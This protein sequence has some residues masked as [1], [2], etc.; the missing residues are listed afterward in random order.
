MKEPFR[1]ECIFMKIIDLNLE[2]AEQF[3]KPILLY[4]AGKYASIFLTY[5]QTRSVVEKIKVCVVSQVEENES[6]FRNLPVKCIDEIKNYEKYAVV[7]AVANKN[8]RAICQ[9]LEKRNLD[10]SYQITSG[11]ID[12]MA[13]KIADFFSSYSIQEKKVF[14]DCFEGL[15]YRCNC[16]YIAEELAKHD[17]KIVWNLSDKAVNDVPN[18]IKVVKRY[19]F[20]YFYEVYTAGIYITNNGVESRIYKRK[21]QKFICT[22]HGSGPFKKINIDLCKENENLKRYIREEYNNIDLFISSSKFNTQII[23]RAFGYEGEVLECGSPRVDC[24]LQK[25]DFRNKIC[26]FYHINPENRI[27]LYAPTFR[28]ASIG[29]EGA[30][31]SSFE[32]YDLQWNLIQKA[33]EMRFEG[34]FVLLYRFHHGLYSFAQS[35]ISYPNAINVT[36]YSDVQELLGAADILITDYSS[37]M[38]DFSLQRKPVFLYQ[39]DVEEYIESRGFYSE[40]DEWPYEK[41][42]TNDELCEKICQFD[43]DKYVMELNYFL[44]KYGTF[45]DGHACRRV[46]E[47]IMQY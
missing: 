47:R 30:I 20:D 39:N 46:M 35:E 17:Y 12:S 2:D 18:R 5:L 7:I 21:N 8:M 15:G 11:L 24:L 36:N 31:I 10:V 4:G 41:A 23:R 9:N 43:N 33:L 26:E 32:K 44:K 13:R 27:V 25:N 40:I 45:D 42:K 1:R 19:S 34:S 3:D 29:D 37:I 14:F 22:W 6:I 28:K 16:K 38:W